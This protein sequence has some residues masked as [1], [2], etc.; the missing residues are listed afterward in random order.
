[1]INIKIKRVLEC[2]LALVIIFGCMIAGLLIYGGFVYLVLDGKI[3][4]LTGLY[5]NAMIIIGGLVGIRIS[6]NIIN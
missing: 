5:S 4:T 1:M 2:L 6:D 3:P